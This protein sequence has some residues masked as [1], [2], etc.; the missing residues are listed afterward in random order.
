[1]VFVNFDVDLDVLRWLKGR[2]FVLSDFQPRV[3]L[4]VVDSVPAKVAQSRQPIEG[5]GVDVVRGIRRHVSL[6]QRWRSGLHRR[7]KPILCTLRAR[8]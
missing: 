6:R 7:P 5:R 1:M 8:L 4:K 2:R 3:A